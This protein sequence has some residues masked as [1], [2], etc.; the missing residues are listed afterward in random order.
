MSKFVH[1]KIIELLISSLDQLWFLSFAD[2]T[3]LR[4]INVVARSG[5]MYVLI[6]FSVPIIYGDMVKMVYYNMKH[7]YIYGLML[8]S[9]L[10]WIVK[11]E[12][13][14]YSDVYMLM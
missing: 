9:L 11:K 4:Y 7:I 2:A 3:K 12:K 8:S 1:P 10:R 6:E 5:S 14:T 13:W